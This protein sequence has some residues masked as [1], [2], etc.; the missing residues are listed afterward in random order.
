[1]PSFPGLSPV[2]KWRPYHNTMVR[3]SASGIEMR[4]TYQA[5]PRWMITLKYDLLRAGSEA[6]LQSLAGFLLQQQGRLDDFLYF[7]DRDYVANNHQFGIGDGVT[8]TFRLWRD[9]GA[10]KAPVSAVKGVPVIRVDGDVVS[11]GYTINEY[12]G[13]VTFTDAPGV[14]AL[15]S[16]TGEYYWRVRCATD[17][18]EYEKFMHQW[19]SAGKIELITVKT[20]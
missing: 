19:W 10:S 4:A 15:L 12:A 2:V 1:M 16:W 8:K 9:F 20:V 5:Y 13:K 17:D 7:D 6:E 14:G 18:Q 11:S 3:E